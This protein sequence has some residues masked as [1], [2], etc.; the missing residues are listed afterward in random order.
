MVPAPAAFPPLSR[1][2]QAGGG[3][4]GDGLSPQTPPIRE[5]LDARLDELRVIQINPSEREHEPRTVAEIADRRNELSGNLSLH[6]ELRFVEKIDQL[7]EAGL[8]TPDGKYRKVM[9]RILELVRSRVSRSLGT[10][11]KLNRDPAFIRELMEHGEARAGEFLDALA[12]ERA[13]LSRDLDS[14]MDFALVSRPPF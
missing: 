14:A 10:A 5:L 3:T 1:P 7:L 13:C 4:Y 11:S 2:A 6:Q 9:V 12:F 8:L